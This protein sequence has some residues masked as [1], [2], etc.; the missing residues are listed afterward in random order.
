MKVYVSLLFL[1]CVGLCRAENNVKVYYEQVENGYAIYA[2]NQEF[3]PM[4][5]KFEFTLK[6]LKPLEVMS[7]IYTI[8]PRENRQLLLNFTVKTLGKEYGLS[9]NYKVNYGNHNQIVFDKDFEYYLPFATSQSYS[10]DQGYN[11]SFSHKNKNAL[12]FSMP[13][14][15]E[16]T[17]ARDGIVIKIIDEFNKGCATEDCIKFNNVLLIYHNDGTFAEYAHIKVK[18]MKVKVGD[19]VKKGQVIALSGNTGW[20]SGPHLHFVLFLQ[21]IDSRE[22]LKT[23]FKIDD[24]SKAVLLEE[25]QKYFRAY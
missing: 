20:S 4:S 19:V 7:V 25:K 15:T 16:I 24:G 9:Y 11:G 1:C 2:D 14:G 21:R 18:G 3:C 23:K 8:K 10:I 5:I 13:Q 6:N 22:T 17:A 12:D